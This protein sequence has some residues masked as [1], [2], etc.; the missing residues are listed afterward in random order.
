VLTALRREYHSLP[1][2]YWTIWFGT[3]INKMGGFVVPFM[4][5]YIT[6]ERHESEATAGAVMSLYGAGSILAGFVGGTLA[7]GLGRR[8]TILLSL[9]GGAAAMLAVGLASS[10]LQIC[11]ATFVMG[12][13]AEMYRPAV[14][15]MIADVVPPVDRQRAYA[16]L[17]WVNNLAFAI[18]PLLAGLAAR[19]SYFTLFAVDAATMVVYGVIVLA[20][21][22]ETRPVE[23]TRAARTGGKAGLG[24]VL[25]DRTFLAFLPLMLG[26]AMVMWQIGTALPIDMSRHGISPGGYGA[27][28]SING[29]MI[30]VLQPFITRA[31]AR[32]SRTR[33]LA[34]SSLL[35]GVGFGLNGVVSSLAGYVLAIAVWTLAEIAN[36]PTSS[37]VVADMAAP[38]LRGRYQGVYSMAWGTA[39]CLGPLL[40]GLLLSGLGSRALWLSCFGLMAL[41]TC[42]HVVLGPARARRERA[43]N[44]ATLAPES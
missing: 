8:A 19:A 41:V 42:G 4:A 32:R 33:V 1:A 27:L 35:F 24:A 29:V 2:A 17:Y 21:V 44:Q 11:A 34:I 36:L 14:S 6:R 18:A 15:A 10:L 9:F 16:H 43:L 12:W 38:A 7:D 23:A 5:L 3:L 28:M 30:V 22:R 13:L 37:A 20:R 26:T 25:S 40:G 31:L 39:S